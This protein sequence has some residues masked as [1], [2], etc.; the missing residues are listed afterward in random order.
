M[1]FLNPKLKKY[2]DEDK[3]VLDVF[4]SGYWRFLII[5]FSI[6]FILGFFIG[7]AG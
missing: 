7:L 6:S 3:G 2:I 1:G 5:V 4:W